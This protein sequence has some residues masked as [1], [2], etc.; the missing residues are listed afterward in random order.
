MRVA[1]MAFFCEFLNFNVLRRM[2]VDV[3]QYV[4]ERDGVIGMLAVIG[5]N[6][7]VTVPY[8]RDE[9]HKYIC[10]HL[11][12][13]QV[14]LFTVFIQ[15][16]VN[17]GGDKA[18]LLREILYTNKKVVFP[19]AADEVIVHFLKIAFGNMNG[20]NIEFDD[21]I[22]DFFIDFC[23]FVK[24]QGVDVA[25]ITRG[26]RD[27]MLVACHVYPTFEHIQYFT[28]VMPVQ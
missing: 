17:A 24:L 10:L 25:Y 11:K 27:G 7:F 22:F 14:F 8:E 18:V 15:K 5:R 6:T 9:D 19:R 12:H 2:D 21:G 16:L 28:V 26:Q 20:M 1:H 4:K 23:D 3:F 13:I